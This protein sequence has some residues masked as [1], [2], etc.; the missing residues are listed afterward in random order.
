MARDG[1]KWLEIAGTGWN[2]WYDW[3]GWNCVLVLVFAGYIRRWLEMP[4]MAR[5]RY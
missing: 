3:N 1:W 5:N 2:D 4:G